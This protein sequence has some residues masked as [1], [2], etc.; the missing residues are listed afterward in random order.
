[1]EHRW[2]SRARTDVEVD[3]FAYPASAGW[4]RIRD[5]ST[6]GC[7]V[8]T[9]I[10]IAPLTH[11]RIRLHAGDRAGDPGF[12]IDAMVVRQAADGLGVEWTDSKTEALIRFV[13]EAQDANAREYVLTS[14]VPQSGQQR[15]RLHS[16]STH[17]S[18][19]ARHGEGDAA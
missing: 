14:W 5:V 12:V 4:G 3:L 9:P 6:S 8:E 10:T 2:G 1:M 19:D 18:C 11:V 15:A 13:H 7:F 17:G 16:P